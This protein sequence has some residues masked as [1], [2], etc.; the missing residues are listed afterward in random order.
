MPFNL[1]GVTQGT[2]AG[3]LTQESLLATTQ[4][5]VERY[6]SSYPLLSL[7]K[8]V[9]H[10]SKKLIIQQLINILGTGKLT[11][12]P[13]SGF[14]LDP[15]MFTEKLVQP[16]F[17]QYIID[18]DDDQLLSL[19]DPLSRVSVVPGT[20]EAAVRSLNGQ[21]SYHIETM[22]RTLHTIIAGMLSTA[23]GYTLTTRDGVEHLIDWGFKTSIFDADWRTG[24][25]D[26]LTEFGRMK[27]KFRRLNQGKDPNAYVFPGNF[28]NQFLLANDELRQNFIVRF[29]EIMRA[30]LPTLEIP[31]STDQRSQSP[32]I[33]IIN[34][35]I[36]DEDSAPATGTDA[37]LVDVWPG[38]I[39]AMA[40]V[41]EMDNNF[42][43]NT[44]RTQDND[45]KGGWSTRFF[46]EEN[47]PSAHVRLSHNYIPSFGRPERVMICKVS[48]TDAESLPDDIT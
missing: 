27:Q 10:D 17:D 40:Y 39:F 24:S 23:G 36:V 43:L 44:V 18:L 8:T 46:R 3:W 16:F 14:R 32:R 48:A 47:P 19:Q 41:D 11:A 42:V 21:M 20:V 4:L 5:F 12:K 38:N 15:Q 22:L 2:A 31:L 37:D 26:V 34:D 1:A 6:L 28:H 25:T 7:F 29:P 13:E 45:F 35:A 9:T 33:I 30:V